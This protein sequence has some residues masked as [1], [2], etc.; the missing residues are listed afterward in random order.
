MQGT[1][2]FMS[3]ALVK[4]NNALHTF[5]DDLELFLYV[6][7]WLTLMYSPS[8]MTVDNCTTFMQQVMD[9]V[10]FAN[11]GSTIKADFLQGCSV[12]QELKFKNPSRPG[13]QKLLMDLAM[14]FSVQYEPVPDKETWGPLLDLTIQ[15]YEDHRQHLQSHQHV[16][17][18]ISETITNATQWP[19]S[20]YAIRQ[21]LLLPANDGKKRK[22]T[23]TDWDIESE[24]RQVKKWRHDSDTEAD[25]GFAP[26]D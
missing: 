14:L 7:L 4:N 5:V 15:R 10:Q 20:D 24:H 25:E 22:I 3:A 13:L 12:L 9:P 8:S 11:A 2:Q 6:I 19:T 1:W 16:I 17:K 18:L 23:K 21:M 26:M